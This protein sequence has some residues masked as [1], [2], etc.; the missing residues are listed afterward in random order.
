MQRDMDLVK[1]ILFYVASFFL[2]KLTTLDRKI[3]RIITIVVSLK[4]K[5]DA[6]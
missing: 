2:L 4:K 5:K 1:K 3:K 6:T